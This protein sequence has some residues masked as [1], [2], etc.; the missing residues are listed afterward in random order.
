M[1]ESGRQAAEQIL[2]GSQQAQRELAGLKT[3]RRAVRQAAL[4]EPVPQAQLVRNLATITGPV[5]KPAR[6]HWAIAPL[7]GAVM[8]FAWFG[9]THDPYRLDSGPTNKT[10]ATSDAA[11]A[12]DWLAQNTKLEVPPVSLAGLG[13]MKQASHGPDWACY[14]FM[15]EGEV[16]QVYV[17]PCT[18]AFAGAKVVH[19]DGMPFFDCKGVG[20]R[21][22]N[23]A[24]YVKGGKESMRWKIAEQA[25]LELLGRGR[26]S[27]LRH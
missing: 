3:F 1:S 5:R 10:Y 11:A 21:Y 7:A 2:R 12:H 25:A 18:T 6:W 9:L 22:R 14:D 8:A 26:E 15:V 27:M 17:K 24:F 20:F 4:Q 13:S 16:Y 19:R 23:L